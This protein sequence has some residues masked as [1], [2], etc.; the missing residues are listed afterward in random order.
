MKGG[1]KLINGLEKKRGR[2]KEFFLNSISKMKLYMWKKKQK[3]EKWKMLK[4]NENNENQ[5]WKKYIGEEFKKK[6]R[7]KWK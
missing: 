6:L 5:T 3:T 4:S 1:Q 7:M 2:I